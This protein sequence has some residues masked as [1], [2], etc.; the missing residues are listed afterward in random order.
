MFSSLVIRRLLQNRSGILGLALTLGMV[1]LAMFAPIIAP[2]DPFEMEGD[3]LAPP[4]KEYIFGTDELGRDLASRVVLASRISVLGSITSV[5]LATILGVPWGL[6]AGFFGGS[7]DSILMRII[8]FMLALPAIL[9][10]MVIMAIVGPSSKNAIIAVAITSFPTF[11]RLSRSSTLAEKEKDYVLA[12]RALGAS[13]RRLI[14]KTI[15]P[16]TLSPILIQMVVAISFAVLL[17]ASL[18]FLG[19]GT[20]PPDPSWGYMLSMGRSY[21]YESMWYGIF[22]GIALTIFVLGLS[23]LSDGLSKSFRT[24]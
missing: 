9:I 1:L 15:M 24:I 12:S 7:I 10:A 19:L 6:I 5:A 17:E 8:D 22:P 11:V 3:M 14:F 20:Q 18:S 21:I 13:D 16:N 2:H 4:S 23:L